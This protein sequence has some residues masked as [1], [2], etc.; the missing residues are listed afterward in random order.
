MRQR[1]QVDENFLD[2]YEQDCIDNLNQLGVYPEY[3]LSINTNDQRYPPNVVAALQTWFT[4]L[5]A[6]FEGAASTSDLDVRVQADPG[7]TKIGIWP[8]KAS[9]LTQNQSAL[10]GLGFKRVAAPGTALPI[11]LEN[12]GLFRPVRKALWALPKQYDNKG[13]AKPNGEWTLTSTDVSVTGDHSVLSKF[14]YERLSSYF[15]AEVEVG[16]FQD[17]S[18][19]SSA[20]LA[21]EPERRVVTEYSE[22]ESFVP[23]AKFVSAI[24]GFMLPALGTAFDFFWAFVT[25]AG[26]VTP[27]TVQQLKARATSVGGL[28]AAVCPT[29]FLLPAISKTGAFRYGAF[30]LGGRTTGSRRGTRTKYPFVFRSGPT[31]SGHIDIT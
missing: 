17:L 22:F 16:V 27:S 11:R 13:N 21:A 31:F 25:Q 5:A 24:L 29:D 4:V 12:G 2:E 1:G 18:I 30:S 15:Y 8:G 23:A 26:Q 20:G 7:F 9:A 6:A 14:D 28:I 10:R 19:D 3:S